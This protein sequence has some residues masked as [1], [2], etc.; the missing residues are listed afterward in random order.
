[1]WWSFIRWLMTIWEFKAPW[2]HGGLLKF[3]PTINRVVMD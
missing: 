1:M 2:L 3:R